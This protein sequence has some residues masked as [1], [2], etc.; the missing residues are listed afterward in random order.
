MREGKPK[1]PLS[2]EQKKTIVNRLTQIVEVKL[3]TAKGIQHDGY[4]I[5]CLAALKY[6]NGDFGSDQKTYWETEVGRITN[7]ADRAFLFLQIAPYFKKKQDKAAFF[8]K[9]IDLADLLSSTYD[10]VSRL[11]MS[12]SECMENNLSDMVKPVAESAFA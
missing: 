3:P 11:D 5:A 10:K 8:Q 2:I 12:I 4:K 1:Q 7:N 9:G 6:V